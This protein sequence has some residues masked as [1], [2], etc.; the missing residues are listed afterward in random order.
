MVDTTD[1]NDLSSPIPGQSLTAE[2][3]ASHPS[4]LV[5]GSDLLAPPSL[6]VSK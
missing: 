1:I 2:L 3:G 5:P 6:P 4:D